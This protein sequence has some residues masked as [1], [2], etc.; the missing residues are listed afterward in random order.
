MFCFSVPNDCPDLDAH[1]GADTASLI[2]SVQ[3]PLDYADLCAH[4]DSFAATGL[5]H[6]DSH[7]QPHLFANDL[8]AYA[9]TLRLPHPPDLC[10]HHQPVD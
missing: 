8:A 4:L 2:S 7:S 10:P 3:C 9:G 1:D 5:P 6:L